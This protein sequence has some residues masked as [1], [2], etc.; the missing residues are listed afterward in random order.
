MVSELGD[1]DMHFLCH[2]AK[3]ELVAFY[4]IADVFL[5][6]SEHEGFCVP[7]IESFYMGVPVIAYAATAVPA[8]MDGGG[9]LITDKEPMQ[10]AA[11]I[12][13]LVTDH[14]LQ[15]RVI[16][17]QDAALARLVA[18]DFGG[19]LLRF[20]DD[21]NRMP[22]MPHPPVSRDFWDQVRR[23]QE[24]QELRKSRPAAF[25]VLPRPAAAKS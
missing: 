9:M 17:G 15:E 20:V 24:L 11:L 18:K 19:M 16:R 21:V 5:C 14:A 4:E 12:D 23:A 6:A 3:E 2:V 25:Q 22:R 1:K 10:V 13:R 7:L 8:T